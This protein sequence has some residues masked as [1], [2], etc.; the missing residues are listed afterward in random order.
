MTTHDENL[1]VRQRHSRRF[2]ACCIEIAH[3]T[4]RSGIGVVEFRASEIVVTATVKTLT[5]AEYKHLAVGQQ[6][7]SMKLARCI[8]ISGVVPGAG[9]WVIQFRAVHRT[10]RVVEPIRATDD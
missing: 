5:A 2:P 10:R 3:V 9:G 6:N 8:E 1:A 4:P 7:R